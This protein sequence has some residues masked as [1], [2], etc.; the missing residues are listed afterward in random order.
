VAWALPDDQKALC[1][2][3]WFYLR[4]S[5]WSL[6]K[7]VSVDQNRSTNEHT[8]IPYSFLGFLTGSLNN[9]KRVA[10]AEILEVKV[11]ARGLQTFIRE[12]LQQRSVTSLALTLATQEKSLPKRNRR[13]PP[14]HPRCGTP[15]YM[16]PRYFL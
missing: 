10:A 6:T 2:G 8:V 12:S 11:D 7:S 3:Q 13:T 5:E 4:V 15:P 9:P 1:S 14:T 16:P